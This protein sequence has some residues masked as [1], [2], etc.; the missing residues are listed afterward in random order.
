MGLPGPG[1]LNKKRWIGAI[2]ALGGLGSLVAGAWHAGA[3]ATF[4][5]ATE[6]APGIVLDLE[7][8]HGVRGMPRD[9]P[10]VRFIDPASGSAIVFKARVGIWPSPFKVGEAVGVAYDP[11][12]PRR[13]DVDSFWTMWLPA[14]AFL[15]F[16]T[17]CLVTGLL[18]LRWARKGR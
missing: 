5:S 13:A 12:D 15:L 4:L 9:H 16:G 10:V 3:A 2:L 17:M 8:E 14:A 1:I 6:R 11:V 7:R 18:T